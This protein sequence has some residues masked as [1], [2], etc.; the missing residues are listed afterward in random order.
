[1]TTAQIIEAC[2]SGK[3][4]VEKV[5]LRSEV[6]ILPLAKHFGLD[7]TQSTSELKYLIVD[8]INEVINTSHNP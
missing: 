6:G 3:W 5:I 8:Y 1:M 7:L 2:Q 4:D